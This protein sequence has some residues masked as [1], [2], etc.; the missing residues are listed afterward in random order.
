MQQLGDQVSI[1]L[2]QAQLLEQE[3]HQRQEL[4][5][6]EAELRVMSTALESAV[7]GISRLDIQG[8][9]VTVNSA[10]ATMVGYQPEEMIGM[11]CSLTVH[12]EDEK[13]MMAAYQ[14]MLS[15]GKAEVEARALR[16]D[17]SVFDVQVVMVLAY[18]RQ[19]QM[20]GHYC[21]MK[22]ISDRREIERMKEEFISV[23]SHE[24]RTP[25]TSIRGALGLLASGLLSTQPQ[26]VNGC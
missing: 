11:P 12:P 24:L 23:V 16:K 25:L 19:Q 4:T 3:I 1:A 13:K 9:Y 5:R 7:E 17:G 18:D 15:N 14:K 21:F 26:K 6:S 2:T 20:S 22:D 8:H 10:Y